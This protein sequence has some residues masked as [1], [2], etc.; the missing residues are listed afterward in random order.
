MML[1]R[2]TNKGVILALLLSVVGHAARAEQ[3]QPKRY[4]LIIGNNLSLDEGI[5]PLSFADDDAAKYYEV[6]SAAGA[7]VELF[8][9]LDPA[10]QQRFTRAAAVARPPRRRDILAS[11]DALFV[12]M[13]ADRAAGRETHFYFIYS[14]HGN[15]GP[16]R[17]GYIFF[18]DTR[19]RRSELF[20]EVLARSPASYNHIILDACHAYF[21]VQKRGKGAEREGNYRAAVLDFL[22]TEDLASYPNTGVILAAS[23]DSETHE[24]NYWESGIFS[25]EL[26]SALLGSADVDGDGVVTYQEAAA[27]VEAANAAIVNPKLRLSV[28]YQPPAGKID[29]PLFDLKA[30]AGQGPSLQFEPAVSRRYYVEDARG[31]RVA[32]L[33]PSAEQ[34]VRIGLIGQAPFFLRTAEKEARIGADLP[35]WM[36]VQKLIFEPRA[37]STRGSADTSFRKHLYEIPYGLGFFRGLLSAKEREGL[38]QPESIGSRAPIG[39]GEKL[40]VLGIQGEGVPSHLSQNLSE[41]LHNAVAALSGYSVVDPALMKAR[42]ELEGGVLECLI[43]MTCLPEAGKVLDAD[44]LISGTLGRI[45]D[46]YQV[47]LKLLDISR[48]EEMERRTETVTG[49]Q[50]NLIQAVRFLAESVLGSGGS[51]GKLALSIAPAGAMIRVDGEDVGTSPLRDSLAVMGGKHRVV[52]EASGYAPHV[53][54]VV[55]SSGG[56]LSLEVTLSR[57]AERSSKVRTWGY[58]AL[59]AAAV[60]GLAGGLLYWWADSAHGSYQQET[61]YQEIKR[62]HSLSADR[63]LASQIVFGA[64]GTIALGGL[65]MVL[66]DM[67]LPE[68]QPTIPRPLVTVHPNGVGLGLGGQW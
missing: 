20:R 48:G 49:R 68:K 21:L 27:C 22:K 12:R 42:G 38:S 18:L 60:T 65:T 7:D 39:V 64:A 57:R 34:T 26:R 2:W 17:E 41:V 56:N 24:W 1:S 35:Q 53:E 44:K 46:S 15:I 11:L 14:G 10:A 50:E 13:Q 62:L 4:A 6:F 47:T 58:R 40:V 8:T 37:A 52:V 67:L 32:D 66:F 5:A 30:L 51:L 31:V 33:F 25:H 36:D 28:Y 63:L 16:N 54:D 29:T 55:V 61:D 45:G 9:V 23:S 43:K 3:A 19:F 59:G